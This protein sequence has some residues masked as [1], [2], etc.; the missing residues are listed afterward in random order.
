MGD[1]KPKLYPFC[2]QVSVM[3][4]LALGMFCELSEVLR[5]GFNE[6][7][8]TMGAASKDMMSWLILKGSCVSLMDGKSQTS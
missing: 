7:L 4:S 2:I 1:L 3:I 6:C 8:R 5:G